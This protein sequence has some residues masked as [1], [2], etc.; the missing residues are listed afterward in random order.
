MSIML[1]DE[2]FEEIKNIVVNMFKKYDIHCVPIS[3]FEIA[4]KM[5][6]KIRPYSA[7]PREKK[8]IFLKKS[9][10]GFSVLKEK[11]WYIY[12]NDEKTYGRINNTIMHEIGHIILDHTEDSE[13]AEKEVK[14]FAKYALC[15]PV[16]VHKL[17]LRTVD[18][19]RT[20]FKISYQAARYALSYYRKWIEYGEKDYTNYEL[21]TIELFN[22]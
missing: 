6:V 20:K 5:N 8:K 17:E 21:Q 16:L 7:Y 4:T 10:D 9:E 14:F 11:G 12:Y 18:E 22:V 3:G 19:I 1:S 15:P 2:R 13:L